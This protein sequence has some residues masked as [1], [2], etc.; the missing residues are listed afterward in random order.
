MTPGLSL[1]VL[2]CADLQRSKAFYEAALGI[3]AVQKRH[4]GVDQTAVHLDGDIVLELYPAVGQPSSRVMLEFAV[5]DPDA[6]ADRLTAAG[7]EART[8]AAIVLAMDPDGSALA[9]VRA[10]RDGRVR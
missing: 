5:D 6:A 4:G 10:H 7:F 9:L 1:I 2:R 8:L 3:A